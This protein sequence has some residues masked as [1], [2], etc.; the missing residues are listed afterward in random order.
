MSSIRTLA[1]TAVPIKTGASAVYGYD[2]KLAQKYTFKS[3]FDDEVVPLHKVEGNF[4]H[5]PRA[6]CPIGMTDARTDGVATVF[7]KEPKPRPNQVAVMEEVDAFIKAGKSGLV[8]C[9]TGWG[10]TWLGYRAA[11]VRQCK[12]LVITTKS[13]IYDQ[14]I[15][16]APT[17]LGIKPSEVGEIR[18][19]KC[20]IIGTKFCVALIHS[21]SREG[22]YPDWIFKE[23]GLV[24]FDECHRLPAEHFSKV[25]WMF[26]ARVRLGL[27]ATKERQDGKDLM[28]NAHIGPIRAQTEAELMVPKVLR[29]ET[30]WKCP[31]TIRVN[32]ETG[33][34][35]VI[36]VPH[37]AGK[38]AHVEKML[39]NNDERNALI[40]RNTLDVYQKGRKHVVFSSTLEHLDNILRACVKLGIPGKDIGK[41]IG[42][43]TKAEIA[44]RDKALARPIMLTTFSM[45]SEGTNFPWLDT[46][47]LAMPRSNVIQIVGR[48]R[49]EYENKAAIVVLDYVDTDS[50]VFESYADS[51][52]KWYKSIGCVIKEIA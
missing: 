48:I 13:D 16:D 30:E 47:S 42:A 12:T 52:L 37:S 9:Y 6:L 33:E 50:P 36:K 40:A 2:L 28:L 14:W 34:R 22:K 49:R 35:S 38:T 7:P 8:C 32:K 10:K 4:I 21:L 45:C 1:T 11:W 25:A 43:T 5:L 51:R 18:Q 46:C 15:A 20:E 44:E 29:V 27:T 31:K 17:F 41:Y 19:D 23:F 26:P 24:I 3:R 39:A